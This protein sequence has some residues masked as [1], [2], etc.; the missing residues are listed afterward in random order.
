[1]GANISAESDAIISNNSSPAKKTQIITFHSSAKWK[2]H[3]EA[4]KQTDKL[5]II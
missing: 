3:F 5:V 2:I 4:A 1:M